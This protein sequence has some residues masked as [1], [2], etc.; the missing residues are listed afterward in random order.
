M[1][2]GS[3]IRSVDLPAASE[4]I[5]IS[6]E[7]ASDTR[8][9]LEF[10]GS[11]FAALLYKYSGIGLFRY[12]LGNKADDIELAKNRFRH[13]EHGYLSLDREQKIG[14]GS[15]S[16]RKPVKQQE[17]DKRR[18]ENLEKY[19]ADQ[20][21]LSPTLLAKCRAAIKRADLQGCRLIYV[22]TPRMGKSDLA[23]VYPVFDK[24]PVAHKIDLSSPNE[25]PEFYSLRYSFDKGHLNEDGS[26]LMSIALAEKLDQLLTP[27][28][29]SQTKMS[30]TR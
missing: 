11:Y 17:L 28:A 24:L 20:S 4:A 25:Y 21:R 22:L 15:T 16:E 8:T 13:S 29:E 26:Q 7:T 6:K 19:N 12:A 1:R 2:S 14:L 30:A 18:I 23:A 3:V 9:F 10:G 27:T 5:L